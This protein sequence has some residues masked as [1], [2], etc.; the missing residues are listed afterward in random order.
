[1]YALHST[2]LILTTYH[3]VLAGLATL[4]RLEWL[5][6]GWFESAHL[7]SISQITGLRALQ[8]RS[9]TRAPGAAQ[10]AEAAAPMV[11]LRYLSLEGMRL[12]SGA[13]R[14]AVV[15]GPGSAG[16]GLGGGGGGD[17]V[18]EALDI[19]LHGG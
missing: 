2:Q 15:A 8:L 18:R 7:P 13:G 17:F 1:M 12:D 10:L 4:T 11:R 6:L 5:S 19:T 16:L 3:S 14:A 9:L